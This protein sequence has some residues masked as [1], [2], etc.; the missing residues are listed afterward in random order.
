[1]L[2][3][4]HLLC[5]YLDCSAHQRSNSL[6]I[7]ALVDEER[8]VV[9]QK[10]IVGNKTKSKLRFLYKLWSIPT[11]CPYCNRPVEVVIDETHDGRNISIR[12][13]NGKKHILEKEKDKT[14]REILTKEEILELDRKYDEDH[15]WWTQKEK[16]LGDKFRQTKT[17]TK[18][19]L[20]QVV[21]WKFKRVPP[22]HKR[23][24]ELAKKNTNEIVQQTCS[25][26]FAMS[27]DSDRIES[28][29]ALHG[30]GPASLS[31]ILT[32][33]DPKNYGV[34]DIHVWREFFGKEP[35][36]YVFTTEDYLEVLTE[37][38]KIAG[39]YG[40]DVRTV[41]KALFK[42]NIDETGS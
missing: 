20:L 35:K 27:D 42:K 31:V 33:Y 11:K 21:D 1:M 17:V 24:T 3:R 19:D 26:V 13:P 41:E 22:R 37:L 40:L 28:L 2:V 16:E 10:S 12:L 25:Q 8:K 9:L 34:F 36:G 14:S 23:V 15:P 29:D 7:R 6:R 39:K 4:N 5:P 32:F 38:R 18:N 30:V